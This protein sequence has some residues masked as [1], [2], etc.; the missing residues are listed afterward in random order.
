MLGSARSE[1]E[2]LW[3]A[4]SDRAMAEPERNA[5]VMRREGGVRHLPETS[6]GQGGGV[7][8]GGNVLI[9]VKTA[10]AGL[11]GSSERGPATRIA[12]SRGNPCHSVEG[13][14]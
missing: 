2:L 4:E 14:P 6:Q 12:L 9:S 3:R 11:S 8:E 13:L 1:A 10:Q 5:A 7:R